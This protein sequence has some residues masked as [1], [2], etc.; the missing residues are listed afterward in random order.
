MQGRLSKLLYRKS[1]VM[2]G[3][4]GWK[5]QRK[6]PNAELGELDMKNKKKQNNEVQIN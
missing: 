6:I 2:Q 5:K 3:A 4:K 1:L